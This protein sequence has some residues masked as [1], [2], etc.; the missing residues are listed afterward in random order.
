MTSLALMVVAQVCWPARVITWPAYRCPAPID[1]YTCQAIEVLP[2]GCG[3]QII[4][5]YTGLDWP[6]VSA[7][8]ELW[9]GDLAAYLNEHVVFPPEGRAP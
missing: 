8:A 2:N 7:V 3:D 1:A 4:A 5:W 9:P 6:V